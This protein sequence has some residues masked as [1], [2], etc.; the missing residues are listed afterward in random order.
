MS[1]FAQDFMAQ[2]GP[3]TTR[4]LSSNLGISKKTAN[5]V[6]PEMIPL[7]FGGLKRQMETQGGAAR[8]DHILN[9]YGQADV[10]DRIDEEVAVRAGRTDVDAR[11]GGLLG[12]AGVQASSMVSNKFKLDPSVAAKLIPVLAPLILGALTKKRDTSPRTSGGGGGGLGG[13]L[14]GLLGRRR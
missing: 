11:L 6:I 1:D 9:K 13:L 2:F 5:A 4:A 8:L 12:D 7:I 10:L 3:Q 14:G